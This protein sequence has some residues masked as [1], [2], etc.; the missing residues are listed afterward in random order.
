MNVEIIGIIASVIILI[1]FLFRK[2]TTIRKINIVG[3][4]FFVIYG[5]I[6]NAISV[7]FLNGMLIVIHLYYL[8]KKSGQ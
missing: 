1:G 4:L 3:A 5:I 2:E 6:N 7:W 8:L